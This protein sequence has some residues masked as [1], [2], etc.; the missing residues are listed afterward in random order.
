[1]K[2]PWKEQLG[3][4]AEPGGELDEET[5]ASFYEGVCLLAGQTYP[6]WLLKRLKA[7]YRAPDDTPFFIMLQ[8]AKKLMDRDVNWDWE[9]EETS[10]ENYG[11]G[12]NLMYQLLIEPFYLIHLHETTKE[13]SVT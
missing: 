3:R 8:H 10:P 7:A 6:E 11:S 2:L 13:E 1:M 5:I 4:S 9:G 12:F